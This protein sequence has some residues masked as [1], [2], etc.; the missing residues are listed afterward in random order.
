MISFS[1]LPLVIAIVGPTAS[2]KTQLA[3]R[4]AYFLPVEVVSADS[5]QIYR[6]MDIGTAKPTP[7]EMARVK[8]HLVD[9]VEPNQPLTLAQYQTLAYA[10]IDQIHQAGKLPLLVG[11]TGLYVRAVLDGLKIPPVPPNMQLREACYAEAQAMGPLH[12]H[13]RLRELDPASADHIDPRNVRRVIRALE[14][15]DALRAPMSALQS[16]SPP[17]FGSLRL[18]LSVP[19]DML[20]QRI[21]T[22]VDQ[23]IADGLVAEVRSLLNHGFSHELPAM[24][25]VGYRQ[26]AMH[27]RGEISLEQAVALVKQQ[28]RR[29]VR[30]QANWFRP[31]DPRIAWLEAVA[32]PAEAALR[33][34]RTMLDAHA[35]PAAQPLALDSQQGTP[36]L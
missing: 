33:A 32:T 17:R 2:G 12:L 24:S 8:H 34:I 4:L 15:C 36:A 21:D 28:T 22:R 5:R 7:Q 20:Y 31:N 30:Q 10:A 3:M 29:L 19:R 23:M 18:G 27:L 16:S 14:V 26:I 13:A 35:D 6:H 25:G 1:G 11:G 9:I